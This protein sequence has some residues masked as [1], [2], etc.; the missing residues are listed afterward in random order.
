MFKAGRRCEQ[1]SAILPVSHCFEERS[2][3]GQISKAML[4]TQAGSFM[5]RVR[6]SHLGSEISA[7]CFTR[8]QYVLRSYRETGS[9]RVPGREDVIAITECEIHAAVN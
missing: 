1:C 4:T 9:S 5:Y 6:L 8:P 2:N 7:E 3:D